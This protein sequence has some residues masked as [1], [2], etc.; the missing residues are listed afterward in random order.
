MLI[1]KPAGA[2]N[3][4]PAAYTDY[5]KPIRRPV[6]LFFNEFKLSDLECNARHLEINNNQL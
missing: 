3:H 4:N 1:S 2:C 5:L 6:Y